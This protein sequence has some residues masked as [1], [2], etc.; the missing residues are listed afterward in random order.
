M[1]LE[2]NI[3]AYVLAGASLAVLLVLLLLDLVLR[4][5]WVKQNLPQLG[6]KVVSIRWGGN[7]R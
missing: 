6:A 5:E 1:T 4:R 2:T 7:R 3:R